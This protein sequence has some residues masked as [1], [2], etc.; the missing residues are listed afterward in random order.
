M[1]HC[2]WL[3]IFDF[4]LEVRSD[5]ESYLE[6]IA[7]LLE[8]FL[9]Q[10]DADV[11][12]DPARLT[13]L[14]KGEHSSMPVILFDGQS[15]PFPTSQTSSDL[16]P[17]ENFY[18]I[19]V[20]LIASRIRTHFLIHAAAVSHRGEGIVFVGEPGYGKSTL[21]MALLKNGCRFLS[22]EFAAI[23][24]ADGYLHP[25]PRKLQV[26]ADSLQRT[27][28]GGVIPIAVPCFDKLALDVDALG[29]SLMS[30]PVPLRY[31]FIL[32]DPIEGDATPGVPPNLTGIP[33]CLP[34]PY[35]Q[36]AMHMLKHY[37][38]GGIKRLL[39]DGYSNKSLKLYIDMINILKD[40]HCFVLHVGQLD[41][42]L[43]LVMEVLHGD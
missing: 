12:Q 28:F 22:D 6:V 40:T 18:L 24:L 9:I 34:L 8:R 35:H 20:R 17:E 10:E 30:D 13:V 11:V 42:E 26:K 21:T 23:R 7:L 27:G 2:L 31:V 3:R 37:Y 4:V 39:Q 36:T 38:Y 16:R 41:Q 33:C 1:S 5:D 43:D 25:F 29:A 19:I 14:A 15:Y 32:Q